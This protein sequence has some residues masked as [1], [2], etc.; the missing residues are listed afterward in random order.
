M[1]MFCS[2]R[3]MWAVVETKVFFCGGC[4]GVETNFFFFLGGG[5]FFL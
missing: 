5:V 1:L 3:C 2:F 4:L